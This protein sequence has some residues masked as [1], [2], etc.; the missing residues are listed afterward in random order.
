M[1]IWRQRQGVYFL[2][3]DGTERKIAILGAG[4]MG[5]VMAE[6]IIAK[7]IA[8]AENVCA[9]GRSNAANLARLS[10]MG[11][12]A[13]LDNRKA[14]E[15]SDV[16]LLAVKPKDMGSLL[17]ELGDSCD[18]KLVVSIAAGVEISTIS[19]RLAG[20]RVVRAMPNLCAQAGMSSTAVS[21]GDGIAKDDW[22]AVEL[23]FSSLGKI[24]WA[25]ERQMAAF[26][27]LAGCMPALVFGLMGK[28]AEF[29]ESKGFTASDA[30]AV[31]VQV[32]KGSAEVYARGEKGYQELVQSVMSK[33]GATEKMFGT[34]CDAGF[35][36]AFTA[37]L[38]SAEKRT[39]ELG[40]DINGRIK[41]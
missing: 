26:T 2:K 14:V 18:G 36:E 15:N 13:G 10:G 41:G 32:F 33:G 6:G 19:G 25:T 28:L 24:V 34:L 22:N 29:A 21:F 27:A 12:S 11:V 7:G 23:L 16:V 40:E 30:A 39:F 37:S 8:R 35:F 20:A 4:N 17:C 9:T 1:F 38:A 31:A 3:A 5:S